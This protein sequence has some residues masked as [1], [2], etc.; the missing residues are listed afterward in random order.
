MTNPTQAQILTWMQEL[1]PLE[2]VHYSW[3][4]ASDLFDP[5]DNRLYEY[6]RLTNAISLRV[7]SASYE[8]VRRSVE[9]CHQ[10]NQTN[11]AIECTIAI[12]G[13]PWHRKFNLDENNQQISP[14][15]PPT[16]F[17]APHHAELDY[18]QTKFDTFKS[19]LDAANA[20]LG[21]NVQLSAILL[22]SEFFKIK[23][24]N[25]L[26]D[27]MHNNAIDVKHDAVHALCELAFPGVKVVQYGRGWQMIANNSTGYMT[28]NTHTLKEAG[29]FFSASLY[30]PN[31][32]GTNREEY[33]RTVTEAAAHGV[34]QVIPWVALGAAYRRDVSASV[35][36]V[37]GPYD[38]DM[39]HSHELGRE[40]NNPFYGARPDQYAPWDKATFVVFFPGPFSDSYPAW[41]KHFIA[42]VRGANNV[43]VLPE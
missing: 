17:G 18:F 42:Y 39:V 14:A 7:E 6:A 5:G 13:S 24:I 16:E 35:F 43:D 37:W 28:A 40:I 23:T 32:P 19:N 25:S 31:E 20:E 41:A 9:V 11:P 21:A 10:I 4:I 2:K 15:L 33:R 3:P 8:F 26:S 12:N 29:E 27:V 22:D 38:Y 34:N 30:R 1:Q 36:R